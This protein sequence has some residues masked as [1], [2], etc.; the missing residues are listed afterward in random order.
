MQ[1]LEE[2]IKDDIWRSLADTCRLKLPGL[3]MVTQHTTW[4]KWYKCLKGLRRQGKGASLP[5]PSL[6]RLVKHSVERGRG[7]GREATTN[8]RPL[9]LLI[10]LCALEA[11]AERAHL[12]AGQSSNRAGAG[13]ALL[14]VAG[15]GWV[16]RSRGP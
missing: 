14:A 12:L 4:D 15:S 2:M 16:P 7:E 8:P 5:G 13:L 11:S 3:P 9:L 6:D 10:F 1:V